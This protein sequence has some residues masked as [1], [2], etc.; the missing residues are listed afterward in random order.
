MI[1]RVGFSCLLVGNATKSQACII[2]YNIGQDLKCLYTISC[3]HFL[4]CL[5]CSTLLGW[6]GQEFALSST[7]TINEILNL[8]FPGKNF[9]RQI[10]KKATAHWGKTTV[11]SNLGNVEHQHFTYLFTYLFWA[12][13]AV[14]RS[15]QARDRTWT[16]A[17]MIPRP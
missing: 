4:F 5:I 15:S 13:P 10:I 6:N 16:I 8:S 3:I 17:M 14:Y 9:P 2:S 1:L 11:L 7:E 12:T